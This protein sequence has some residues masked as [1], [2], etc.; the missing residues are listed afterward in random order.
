MFTDMLLEN[1]INFIKFNNNLMKFSKNFIRE[2]IV[3]PHIRL[4]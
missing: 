1:Y 2:R 3:I 4:L